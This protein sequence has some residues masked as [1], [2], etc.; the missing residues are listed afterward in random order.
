MEL[1]Q[2]FSLLQ[3]CNPTIYLDKSPLTPSA[4]PALFEIQPHVKNP[5]YDA[6]WDEYP[7]ISLHNDAEE[8]LSA[9]QQIKLRPSP[10][11]D[12]NCGVPTW[13]MG[14]LTLAGLSA[15]KRGQ[16]LAALK[17]E[18]GLDLSDPDM[19]Y[20][21]VRRSRKVGTALHPCVASG[22]FRHVDPT[23][24]VRP[25]TLRALKNLKKESSSYAV[26]ADG[27]TGYLDFYKTFG[28]HFISAV[29]I[30]DNLFQ[31]GTMVA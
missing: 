12:D 18:I 22:L 24:T 19:S 13:P 14:A 6:K 10:F 21:L 15:E 29:D 3:G 26:S 8:L 9:L 1:G 5:N 17:A 28:S 31:V 7:V 16:V 27:A 11:E 30:G 23:G 4:Q 25:E 2:S 20:A